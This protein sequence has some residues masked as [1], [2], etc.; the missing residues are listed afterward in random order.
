MSVKVKP[1]AAPALATKKEASR[2]A[3]SWNASAPKVRKVDIHVR[4]YT[5]ASGLVDFSQ[6]WKFEDEPGDPKPGRIDLPEGKVAYEFHFHLHDD[7]DPKKKLK[8]IDPCE[9]AMWVAVGTDCPRRAGNGSG[10]IRFGHPYNTHQ[11]VVDDLNSN[12]P[13]MLFK[14]ALRFDGEDGEQVGKSTLCPPYEYDPDFKNG[15]GN[16]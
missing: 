9:E 6:E 4:A 5:E 1:S 8:F 13:A 10:Q 15:G 11:L 16:T 2:S 12:V 3:M 7:T 14:Y